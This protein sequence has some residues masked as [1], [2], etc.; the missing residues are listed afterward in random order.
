MKTWLLSLKVAG[1]VFLVGLHVGM[2][3]HGAPRW[4]AVPVSISWL[5]LVA[6]AFFY[7]AFKLSEQASK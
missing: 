3:W 6:C 2:F 7:G 4:V 1:I 5:Y